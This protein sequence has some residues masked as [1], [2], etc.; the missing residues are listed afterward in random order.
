MTDVMRRG[1]R[2]LRRACR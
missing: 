1:L 2:M